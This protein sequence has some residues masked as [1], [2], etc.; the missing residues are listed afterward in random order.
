ML[1]TLVR[2]PFDRPGWVYE[3][4][5]DGFRLLA[6]KEGARVTL[7][8]RNLKV[9]TQSFTGIAKAVSTLAP[10]TLLLDGEVVAFDQRGMSRFQLLQNL[11]SPPRYAVF[12]CLYKDGRDLRHQPLSNRRKALEEVIDATAGRRATIFLSAR[13]SDNGLKAYRTTGSSSRFTKKTSSSSS[14]ILRLRARANTS[15]RCCSAHTI[16]ASWSTSARWAPVSPR[17]RWPNSTRSFSR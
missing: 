3:V 8:S 4:K 9:R 12:D 17:K 11:Q 15:A 7:L 14:A 2:E 1:A 13:L 6:Y 5:Y 16:M 10:P